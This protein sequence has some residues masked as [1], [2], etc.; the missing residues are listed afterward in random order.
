MKAPRCFFFVKANS[1]NQVLKQLNEKLKIQIDAHPF[2]DPQRQ[3][4]DF[5]DPIF[6]L[7]WALAEWVR[8]ASAVAAFFATKPPLTPFW[9]TRLLG[10]SF[11]KRLW[12]K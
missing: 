4:E 2:Q 3:S 6:R 10:Q 7:E 5:E 1:L 9:T 11:S 12:L 8:E